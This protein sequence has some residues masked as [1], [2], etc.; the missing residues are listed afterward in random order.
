[1]RVPGAGPRGAAIIAALAA[2]PPGVALADVRVNDPNADPANSTTQ[3]ETSV[4]VHG[5]TVCAGWLDTGPPEGLAG[6]GRSEDGGAS[7][8][9]LGEIGQFGDPSLAAHGATGTFYYARIATLAGRPAIGVSRSIDGCR[10]FGPATDASPVS[11]ALTAT[12][13]NDKPWIAVDNSGGARNGHLYACWTRFFDPDGDGTEDAAELRVSSSRD[14]AA[15]WQDEQVLSSANPFGCNVQVGPDGRVHVA[16]VDRGFGSGTLRLASSADGGTTFG[17]ARTP[18]RGL[19]LAHPGSDRPVQCGDGVRPTLTGDLLQAHQAWLAVDGTRGRHRGNL[20]LVA[21]LDAAGLPDNADIVFLRSTSGGRRW[22][23]PIQ[24][25]AGGGSTDQFEPNLAVGGRGQLALA[26]YDRRADRTANLAIGLYGTFSLDGGQS[27][28][29][30]RRISDGSFPPP[31]LNPIYDP[32]ARQCH[33]GE[34]LG[35]AA[36]ARSAYYLWTDNRNTVV[37]AQYPAGRRDPDI[38]FDRVALPRVPS[39][40][41]RFTGVR[42]P[43]GRTLLLVRVPGRGELELIGRG[44]RDVRRAPRSRGT[45]RLPIRPLRPAR[46]ASRPKRV[47]VRVTFTPR[48]GEPR[49]ATKRVRL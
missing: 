25:G 6:L 41:F 48:H 12:T 27:F 18:M 35:V 8:A 39:S 22:S 17:P 36:D 38:F 47:R 32:I 23:R 20:Y 37:N 40:R 2:L 30:V 3:F 34:Y 14:G 4:A 19:G 21:V 26:W 7:F 46:S 42:R 43:R 15:T 33:W 10:S 1:M 11:S 5:D 16:W 49:S 28:M 9:D 29:P 13:F 45:V 31:P 24:V 44:V